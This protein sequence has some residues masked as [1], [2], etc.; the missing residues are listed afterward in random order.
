MIGINPVPG[1]LR[2]T[3]VFALGASHCKVGADAPTL[4]KLS[5]V[6]LQQLPFARL[7]AGIHHRVVL[8]ALVQG[9]ISAFHENLGPL[10]QG[11]G[12]KGGKSTDEDFLEKGGVHPIFSS[13]DSARRIAKMPLRIGTRFAVFEPQ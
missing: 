11:S 1:F 12:K 10:D 6:S 2:L 7:L 5:A 4:A 9:V 13:S 8:V 3:R